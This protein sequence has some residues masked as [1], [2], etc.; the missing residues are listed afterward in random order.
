MET[1]S[2]VLSYASLPQTTRAM[3]RCREC[4][5]LGSVVPARNECAVR[6]DTQSLLLPL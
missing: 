2:L 3:K 6:Q 4:G 5:D 1:F